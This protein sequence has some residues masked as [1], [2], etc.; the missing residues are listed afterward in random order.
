M[1]IQESWEKALKHTEIVRPRVMPLS[2][3]SDTNLSYIFLAKSRLSSKDTVIREGSVVIEK[4]SL[5]LLPDLP[6]F[7]GFDFEEEMGMD[8]NIFTNF[9]LVRGIKF[10]SLKFNNKTHSLEVREE[11][12]S[13]SLKF[14]L[15]KFQQT[16]NV[17]TGLI[18][19]PADTWQFSI[20]IFICSQ[21]LKNGPS[22]FRRLIEDFNEK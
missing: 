17:E 11:K 14:Y 16:E 2:A 22:D 15:D 7:E 6:Q 1:N 19:G 12:L 9:L 20:L 4:P 8:E 5:I 21:V 13:K 10:P 3:T 18:T